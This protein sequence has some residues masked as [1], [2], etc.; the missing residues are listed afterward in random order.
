M[1]ENRGGKINSNGEYIFHFSSGPVGGYTPKYTRVT[2]FS[3]RF[4]GANFILHRNAIENESNFIKGF[5]L[6]NG[7]CDVL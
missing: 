5:S 2:C 4:S 3:P 7:E 6:F 1:L